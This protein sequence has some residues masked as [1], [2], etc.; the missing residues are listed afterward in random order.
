MSHGSNKFLRASS[1]GCVERLIGLS[2]NF[3]FHEHLKNAE[4][5]TLLRDGGST[6][7]EACLLGE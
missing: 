3:A 2:H 7:G 1:S 5:R 6:N 4:E